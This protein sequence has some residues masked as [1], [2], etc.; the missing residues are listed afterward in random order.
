MPSKSSNWRSAASRSF[1][2]P[3]PA[4]SA[5][6]AQNFDRSGALFA[7]LFRRGLPLELRALSIFRLDPLA[8][9]P[10]DLGL[11]RINLVRFRRSAFRRSEV[12][13][14]DQEECDDPHGCEDP[15]TQ[16]LRTV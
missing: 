7:R 4:N 8:Q 14:H 6:S 12:P 2:L 15:I 1:S 3:D 11:L 5:R 16:K 13:K 10:L 9:S